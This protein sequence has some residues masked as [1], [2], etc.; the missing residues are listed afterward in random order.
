M[1][2]VLNQTHYFNNSIPY[3]NS[4]NKIK[5][6]FLLILVHAISI[7]GLSC[8]ILPSKMKID[9]ASKY[10]SYSYPLK[11]HIHTIP[12]LIDIHS[13]TFSL[14]HNHCSSYHPCTCIW[15]PSHLIT[16]QRRHFLANFDSRCSHLWCNQLF[17]KTFILASI[18][19]VL[20][21]TRLGFFQF[22]FYPCR[23]LKIR[24]INSAL[25]KLYLWWCVIL[26]WCALSHMNNSPKEWC[27]RVHS[28]P[29][30]QCLL[31]HSLSHYNYP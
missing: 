28:N 18:S 4:F 8:N 22:I 24:I 14:P 27:V 6:Y 13:P 23:Y 31:K 7:L 2:I 9:F 19:I 12:V 30:G 11:Q 15:V 3:Y 21:I 26:T 10:A 5:V 25:Y 17:H 20:I 1:R 29:I 16:F